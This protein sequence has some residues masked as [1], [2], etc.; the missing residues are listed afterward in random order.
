MRG[1]EYPDSTS[2]FIQALTG[3][4]SDRVKLVIDDVL[5]PKPVHV[6]HSLV[7]EL[8]SIRDISATEINP[9]IIK[10]EQRSKYDEEMRVVDLDEV[11]VTA[12]RIQRQEERRITVFPFNADSDVTIGKDDLKKVFYRFPSDYLKSIPGLLVI[13]S[14]LGGNQIYL[15]SQN[16]FRGLSTPAVFVDGIYRPQF[17][18]DEI[19]VSE[20]ESIDV[21]KG[22]SAAVFGLYGMNGVISVTLKNGSDPADAQRETFNYKSFTPTGYQKPVDFYAPRYETLEAKQSAVPDYRTTIFWKPD[23][24]ITDTGEANFEFYT[25]DFQTTY[26]V[27]IEGITTDGQLIR[28]VGK[29]KVEY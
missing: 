24:V 14:V 26:S 29:K 9:L 23:V 18:I 11:V 17:S 1:F 10:A 21:F 6:P 8:P 19:P 2:Y 15:T 22:A 12:N 4:G 25:A 16:N 28:Q 20:I 27:V 3:R 5:F 7:T 13:S